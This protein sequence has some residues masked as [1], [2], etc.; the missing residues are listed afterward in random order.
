MILT[1]P[2]R[3]GNGLSPAIH[4]CLTTRTPSLQVG[5]ILSLACASM[6]GPLCTPSCIRPS[7]NEITRAPSTRSTP[8]WKCMRWELWQTLVRIILTQRISSKT[9]IFERTD[10]CYIPGGRKLC[11]VSSVEVCS[12]G[13][14]VPPTL[15]GEVMKHRLTPVYIHICIVC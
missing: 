14:K 9:P 8:I 13:L 1:L 6:A 11:W 4:T 7:C 3:S 5:S 15:F 2:G 12:S 10:Q